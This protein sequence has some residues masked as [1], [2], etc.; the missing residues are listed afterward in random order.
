MGKKSVPF[1]EKIRMFMRSQRMYWPGAR[2]LSGISGGKD[3]LMLAVVLKHVSEVDDVSVELL[4]LNFGQKGSELLEKH[5]ERFASELGLPLKVWRLED[6][7]GMRF[8]ELVS[9]L[10]GNPCAICSTLLRYYLL[11]LGRD[12]DA[13][14]T[15]HNLDDVV[16]FYLYNAMTGNVSFSST[17]RPVLK[18][19]V[20]PLKI[21][22]FFY[23]REEK[24]AEEAKK[25]G[26]VSFPTG[27]PSEEEAPTVLLRRFLKDFERR[28]PG[29]RKNLL[30]FFL[31]K[32]EP[33]KEPPNRCEI[34]GM[35]TSGR[36]CAVCK[37]KKRLGII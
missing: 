6:E 18:T 8:D 9:R 29:A 30:R 19:S 5:V 3:S 11:Y 24:I 17:L 15:G 28:V 32:T 16:S 37:M 27:C 4:H 33:P 31:E 34:C 36:I 2:I 20:G 13:V 22:P 35:P 7:W 21:R 26:I 10:R 14:A 12:Y 25:R 1:E 23:V